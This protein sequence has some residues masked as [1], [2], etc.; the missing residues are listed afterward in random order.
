MKLHFLPANTG[1]SLVLED[2]KN[3]LVI[4]GGM[5]TTA[6]ALRGIINGKNKKCTI[7]ITHQ[8]NDHIGGI[9]QFLK[10]RIPGEA[11]D[12]IVNM[13]DLHYF[14][15]GNKVSVGDVNSLAGLLRS[16]DVIYPAV[17]GAVIEVGEFKLRII[18][19]PRTVLNKYKSDFEELLSA[20]RSEQQNISRKVSLAAKIV[21]CDIDKILNQRKP[22]KSDFINRTSIAMIVEANKKVMLFLGDAH[23]FDID[24]ALGK[25]LGKNEELQCDIV[26]ISHH[27]SVHSTSSKLLERIRCR[28]YMIST[29]S[30]GAYDHPHAPVLG[31]IVRQA[32]LHDFSECNFFFNYE[33]VKNAIQFVNVPYDFKVSAIFSNEID[34]ERL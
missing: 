32:Y 24:L 25:F 4:D 17:D 6:A 22:I 19:P 1:D 26:K 2:D 34:I 5:P 8:D 28:N 33:R 16:D 23:P 31:A 27:G 29:N 3:I 11:F 10:N 18:S 14:Q 13:P 12:F 9:V 7:V 21:D 20:E 30:A 15:S